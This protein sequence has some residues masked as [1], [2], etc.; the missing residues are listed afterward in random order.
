M[1]V[2][3]WDQA[4]YD[5]LQ[6]NATRMREIWEQGVEN[7]DDQVDLLEELNKAVDKPTRASTTMRVWNKQITV[8]LNNA[9]EK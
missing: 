1:S 6:I 3:V 9:E 4:C 2:A 8:S 5:L 7:E